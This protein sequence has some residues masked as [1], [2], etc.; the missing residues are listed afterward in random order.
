[1]AKSKAT[2]R[3]VRIKDYVQ[4]SF[5][6]DKEVIEQIRKV[7][8]RFWYGADKV[9]KFPVE[10][11]KEFHHYTKQFTLEYDTVNLFAPH[12]FVSDRFPYQVRLHS[13][14]AQTR[15]ELKEQYSLS[16]CFVCSPENALR[17]LSDNVVLSDAT[18]IR[19]FTSLL[20]R[21]TQPPPEIDPTAKILKKRLTLM[22]LQY[23]PV[24]AAL[25]FRRVIIGDEMGLGKTVVAIYAVARLIERGRAKHTLIVCEAAK[26][27]DW[28]GEFEKFT[29]L[30][31]KVIDGSAA[32][33]A[34]QLSEMAPIMIVNY[35]GLVSN[36]DQITSFPWDV[37]VADE[38]TE[39]KSFGARKTKA[40]KELDSEYM[41]ML[42]G[43]VVD[44]DLR[45]LYNL[46]SILQPDQWE[47]FAQFSDRYM[48]MDKYKQVQGYKHEDELQERVQGLVVRR[49]R[50]D[51]EVREGGLDIKVEHHTRNLIVPLCPITQKIYN[52]IY[53]DMQESIALARVISRDTAIL[54]AKIEELIAERDTIVSV[55]DR[56]RFTAEINNFRDRHSAKNRELLELRGLTISLFGLLREVCD[57]PFMLITSESKVAPKYLRM[58]SATGAKSTKIEK[59]IEFLKNDVTPKDKV[60]VFSCHKRA[61]DLI[62]KEIIASGLS[63]IKGDQTGYFKISGKM[64]AAKKHAQVNAFKVRP[65]V[66]LLL[67]TDC[68]ARGQN[69]Q[70]AQYVVNF[71]LH[72]NPSVLIQRNMRT[73]RGIDTLF[74]DL[75]TV[76]LLTDTKL[77]KCILKK[78]QPKVKMSKRILAPDA[79]KSFGF[80]GIVELMSMDV[81]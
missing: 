27:F 18:Y 79:K 39:I 72:Y 77:E 43:T 78:L 6:Y 30:K 28:Q 14:K 29:W 16:P 75:Y 25:G 71:D 33:R 38:V 10:S 8:G 65:S 70:V 12:L 54:K 31:T 19:E 2:I 67:T 55:P 76:N 3:L 22:P 34:E 45:E 17:A 5:A 57:S 74:E 26:K 60:I 58:L 64:N 41:W 69:F 68:L 50:E 51:D 24:N 13:L 35:D 62:E 59:L 15:Q 9:W 56:K 63:G 4:A 1:M 37:V 49:F 21:I 32:K 20:S 80:R 81:D 11:F 53:A 40:F 46:L 23:R 7:D 61:L 73:D 44:N 48:K 42:S 52:V 36:F 66:R 47:P